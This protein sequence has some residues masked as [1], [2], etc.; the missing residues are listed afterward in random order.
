MTTFTLYPAIDLRAGQCVRLI[1]GDP[2]RQEVF[3]AEPAEMARRWA[4]EGARALHVVDLDGAFSGRP[5]QLALL[6][7]MAAAVPVPV[8]F[9]GGLRT[10]ADVEAAFSAGAARIVVGTRALEEG[11]LRGL[12]DRWGAERIVAGLDARGDSVAVAG[13][14]ETSSLSLGEA[15]RRLFSWGARLAV[16]TQV[17]RDGM[18][19]GPDLDGMRR[20]LG[21]GLQVIAS[22]GV[23]TVDDVRALAAMHGASGAILGRA[24]YTGRI[25][26]TD[27]L[28]AV[29]NDQG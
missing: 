17:Q 10:E 11:F 15:A 14:Q 28:Q 5:A 8:Q 26:L 27:A 23:T 25:T 21:T 4:A 6:A 3:S 9:G 20:V 24:L 1:Q 7:T 12:I 16:Y 29:P 2:R 13:W 18:L 22:G 19:Q